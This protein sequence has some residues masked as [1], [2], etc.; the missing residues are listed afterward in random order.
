MNNK[1]KK[2]VFCLI[3]V[4]STVS[5]AKISNEKIDQH[6]ENEIIK[7][8]NDNTFIK[9]IDGDVVDKPE[10]NS[11]VVHY[12]I[13]DELKSYSIVQ[14]NYGII[15]NNM[16]YLDEEY[17]ISSKVFE[18]TN[19]YDSFE[20]FNRRMYAINT[21][22]DRKV[23]YPAS[24]IY[25]SIVPRPVRKGISNFFR[26]FDEVPTFVN[27]L[28]QLKPKKAF[29]A[30]GRFTINSTVGILGLT[31]P[32]AKIGMKKDSE[33]MGDTLGHYGIKTGSYLVLPI[34]GPST[35]RDSIGLLA[36]NTV[37][38]YVTGI[39][40]ENLF[41]DTGV[42]DKNIYKH[43]RPIVTG[44]NA[45]SFIGFRYGDLNSP[46]EYDLVRAFYYNFRKIQVK[47]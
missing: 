34:L 46:F 15:A 28:L 13:N 21:Q 41:F 24:V 3:I 38:G 12:K 1:N 11:D 44:L 43:T 14:D 30:L 17:I 16:D 36:D 37:E 31:D 26:N 10:G 39:A 18:L 9:F 42:F 19:I 2:L 23:I 35:L 5:Q 20:P 27:S 29:N 25:P 33:T 8:V 22:L 45:R 4:L 47:K 32:A 6:T 7:E 40:E